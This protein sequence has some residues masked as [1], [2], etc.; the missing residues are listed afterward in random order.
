MTGIAKINRMMPRSTRL[1]WWQAGKTARINCTS[2][3][4]EVA[5][6]DLPYTPVIAAVNLAQGEFDWMPPTLAQAALLDPKKTYRLAL[7]L[8]NA[9]GQ[10][11]ELMRVSVG[12]E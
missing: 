6:T 12:V 7:R 8:M 2:F 11:V 10:P 3:T 4:C 5:E 1:R 9:G